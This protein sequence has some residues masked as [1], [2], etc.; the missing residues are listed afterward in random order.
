MLEQ[1]DAGHSLIMRCGV[2]VVRI[3]DDCIVLGHALYILRLFCVD[4]VQYNLHL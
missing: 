2:V 1:N 3:C 4:T